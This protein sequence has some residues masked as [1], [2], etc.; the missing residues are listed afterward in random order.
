M[1]ILTDRPLCCWML[2]VARHSFAELHIKAWK[3]GRE[4]LLSHGDCGTRQIWR[5]SGVAQSASSTEP[6]QNAVSSQPL[7]YF[8]PSVPVGSSTA[9]RT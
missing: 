9:A 4:L 2:I 6:K 8:D 1:F 3:E 5:D 7:P